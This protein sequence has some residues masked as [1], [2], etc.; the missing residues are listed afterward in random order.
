MAL[1]ILILLL[2]L[3]VISCKEKTKEEIEESE[4]KRIINNP[5]SATSP[6]KDFKTTIDIKEPIF[7]AGSV[8]QGKIIQHTFHYTNT[9][10]YPYETIETLTTCGCTIVE[11]HG[12]VVNPDKSDSLTVYFDTKDFWGAQEKTIYLIGN[13]KPKESR[14]TIKADIFIK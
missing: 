4:I 8:P 7:N 12:T 2:T 13:T 5:V 9:G 14:F 10:K 3:S 6:S 11:K 1:R